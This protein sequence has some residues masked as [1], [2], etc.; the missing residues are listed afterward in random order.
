VV[1]E[2]RGSVTRLTFDDS[3][4]NGSPVWS[5]DGNRIV[6]SAIEKGKWGLYQ[7]L[8]SG[9]GTEELLYE[10]ET[11]KAPMSWSPDGKSN[12]FWVQYPRTGGDLWVLSLE[13]KKAEPLINS[14]FNETHGQISPDGKWIAYTSN[15]TGRN[16]IYVQPFPSGSGRYQI[17]YHGGDWPRWK[18]DS[19]ELFFHSIANTLDA[20]AVAAAFATGP[21]FSAPITASGATLVPGSP[22]EIVRMGAVNMPH[23]GGDYQTYAVSADGQRILYTQYAPSTSAAAASGIGPDPAAGL[24]VARNWTASLK[25]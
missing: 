7:V 8:S 14:P 24:T 21:L 12:V 16:E 6:Y 3:H 19:K 5:P 9:S 11:L 13:D 17:S 18:S 10:S 2:P 25:K 20:P 4:H 15:S 22:K 23:S 1:I